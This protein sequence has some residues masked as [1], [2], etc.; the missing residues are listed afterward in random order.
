[1]LV[2]AIDQATGSTEKFRSPAPCPP[3][4]K[5]LEVPG[6][7]FDGAIGNPFVEYSFAVFGRP[8]RNP[9]SLCDCDRESRPSL[10]QSLY[11]ANHP[12]VLRKIADP[13]GRLAQIVKEQAGRRR[14]D[15]RGLPL[16]AEPAAHA[17][18][19]GAFAWST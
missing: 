13:K 1:M 15:R 16:D 8:S 4:A 10:L 12:E 19:N 14:G 17:R 6:S 18:R 11:L 7:V 5:A 9:E 3:G 2:D